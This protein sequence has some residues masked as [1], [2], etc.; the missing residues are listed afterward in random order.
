MRAAAAAAPSGSP[1]ASCAATS[2][3]SAAAAWRWCSPWM[4]GSPWSSRDRSSCPTATAGSPRASR[5]RAAVRA[6]SRPPPRSGSSA[7]AS[8]RRPCRRRRSAR[9]ASASP[10]TA[11]PAPS[12]MR[13]AAASSRSAAVHW[14]LPTSTLPYSVRQRAYRNG[15]PYLRVNS[16]ATRTHC[17]ARCRSPARS[18]ATSMPQQVNTTVSRR[19]FSPASA[20]AMAS[21]I[22]A[23]P[24]SASPTVTSVSP[25][26]PRA[27]SSR[28][29]S[30]RPWRT[31]GRAPE[32]PWR[33]RGRSPG[34]RA[35]ATASPAAG[36]GRRRP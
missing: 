4:L 17:V 6:A 12:A 13:T 24:A 15:Q 31:P 32:A 20:P 11:V 25:R 2:V 34:S 8:S 3:S 22:R 23:R 16:S 26:S 35:A 28:S 18:Q 36:W 30:R 33:S 14:P 5:S 10:C 21:S 1:T 19:L 7:S 9:R 27:H 29:R